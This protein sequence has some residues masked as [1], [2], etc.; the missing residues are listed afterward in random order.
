MNL[1]DFFMQDNRQSMKILAK[2]IFD[3]FFFSF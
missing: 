2:E 3:F 1:C